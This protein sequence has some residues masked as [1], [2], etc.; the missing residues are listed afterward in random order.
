MT[1][2]TEPRDA[3]QALDEHLRLIGRDMQRWIELFADEAVVEF[4]YA[5]ALGVTSRLEG[6]EAIDR[7]FRG[8]LE[9]FQ[10]L[11]F[12]DVRRYRTTDPDVTIAEAHGSATITTTGKRYE[13]DYV[14]VLKTKRGKIVLYREYWSPVAAREAFSDADLR[15]A[16]SAS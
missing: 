5:P 2:N 6:K 16:G 14:W 10:D 7:H 11:V 3:A 12:R 1:T 8:I 15:H 9:S 13:Q 4:P